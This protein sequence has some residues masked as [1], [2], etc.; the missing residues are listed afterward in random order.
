ML[1]QKQIQKIAAMTEERENRRSL[2]L[3]A[4]HLAGE[5]GNKITKEDVE[6]LSRM[7]GLHQ[8]KIWSVISFYDCFNFKK[9]SRFILKVC[10]GICCSL[11]NSSRLVEHL[12]KRL[13]IEEGETT[14]DELFT[15]Q[16]V[17]C[18]GHCGQGPVL[19]VNNGK[20]YSNI[21]PEE[22][23]DILDGLREEAEDQV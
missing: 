10:R 14:A 1:T 6:C 16:V 5:N 3:P 17:D 4:L 22:A 18:R 20:I 23:N 13:N 19:Q 9:D 15:L 7:L 21:T 8:Q 2:L 12:K 11:E